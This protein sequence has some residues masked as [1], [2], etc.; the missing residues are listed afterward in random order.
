MRTE[1]DSFV[2]ISRINGSRVRIWHFA[3]QSGRGEIFRSLSTIIRSISTTTFA[4]I[5]RTS[6]ITNQVHSGRKVQLDTNPQNREKTRQIVV[7]GALRE[8][9]PA[10]GA[11]GGW[12]HERALRAPAPSPKHNARP[13]CQTTMDDDLENVQ[14]YPGRY[15]VELGPAPQLVRAALSFITMRGPIG[16]PWFWEEGSWRGSRWHYR[17]GLS[18]WEDT[19]GSS[20]VSNWQGWCL[21]ASR[22]AR[23]SSFPVAPGFSSSSRC[24]SGDRRG[25]GRGEGAEG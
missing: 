8:R 10:C 4:L 7:D 12:Y 9:S 24:C 3:L 18:K 11:L 2:N 15:P 23:P 16:W 5:D 14:R 25:A 17:T 22:S 19:R 13:Q 6:L 20:S 1:D 21:A